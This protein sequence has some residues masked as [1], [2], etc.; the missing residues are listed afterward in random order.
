MFMT[1]AGATRGV[2]MLL[3]FLPKTESLPADRVPPKEQE[4]SHDES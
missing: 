3:E 2:A 1:A 4:G